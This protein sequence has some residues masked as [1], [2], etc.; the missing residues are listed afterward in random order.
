MA[1]MSSPSIPDLCRPDPCQGT[2]IA[3]HGGDPRTAGDRAATALAHDLAAAGGF[4][5]EAKAP[6]TRRA[7][8]SD[9]RAYAAWC[10]ARSVT[11]LPAAPETVAA[12]LAHEAGRGLKPSSLERRRAAIRFLHRSAGFADPGRDE[13]VR[14]TLA[15]IRRTRGSAPTRK[16]PATVDRLVAMVEALPPGFVGTRDRAL[17]LLGFAGAFRRAELAGLAV[18]DLEETADG[19]LVT[20]R[21]SKT[22]PN[23]YGRVV[24]VI[25][26]QTHCP[27][28]ALRRWLVVSGILAGP[29]FRAIGVGDR[30]ADLALSPYGVAVIVKRAAARAGFDPAGFAGHSLRRGF[31]TSAAAHGASLFKLRDVSGHASLDCLTGYVDAAERFQDHAGAG[32]L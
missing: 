21:R 14:A 31:L 16:Q 18:E 30:L 9:L 29:V 4:A 8:A 19:L 25:R 2:A 5:A 7:Y 3:D 12:F 20:L 26:G 6:A 11:P 10:T 13:S 28:A 32:L 22:D 1:R 23:G 27:V 17:L 24:P 15:G